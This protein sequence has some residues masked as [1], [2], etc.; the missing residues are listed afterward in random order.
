MRSLAA[1]SGL[2]GPSL[3]SVFQTY[4]RSPAGLTARTSP[5]ASTTAP[6]HVHG[7]YSP[8]VLGTGQ[9]ST[10]IRRYSSTSDAGSGSA[11]GTSATAAA[12]PQMIKRYSTNFAYRQN[13]ERQGTYGSSL[14]SEGSGLVGP[15]A[16]PSSY[17]YARGQGGSLGSSYG[18]SLLTRMEYR[19]GQ[20][21]TG[22][23]NMKPSNSQDET[24]SATASPLTRFRNSIA[25]TYTSAGTLT[26]SPRSQ[27]E[28]I[29]AFMHLLNSKPAFGSSTMGRLG[30][31]R[32]E[33][34]SVFALGSTPEENSKTLLTGISGDRFGRVGTPDS[35]HA[36]P[37]SSQRL[38]GHTKDASTGLR[39]S[40]Y[41][42]IRTAHPLSR[43]Q[44]D[45]MLSRMAESVGLVSLSD[46]ATPGLSKSLS[47]ADASRPLLAQEKVLY[48]RSRA[49]LITPDTGTE[50]GDGDATLGVG[51]TRMA[52]P[53]HLAARAAADQHPSVGLAHTRVLHTI[54]GTEF[55]SINTS[56]SDTTG[57]GAVANNNQLAERTSTTDSNY[58]ME[59]ELMFGA[60]QTTFDLE[61]ELP[62]NMD[63]MT[64]EE[65]SKGI[66]RKRVSDTNRTGLHRHDVTFDRRDA[67]LGEGIEGGRGATL[68]A[69]AH[70]NGGQLHSVQLTEWQRAE[71]RERERAQEVER[72]RADAEMSRNFGQ[73]VGASTRGR[74]SLSPWR[75]SG[76]GTMT[77][78]AGG[79]ASA[80]STPSPTA[81]PSSNPLNSTV[82][83]KSSSN[84]PLMGVGRSGGYS[85]SLTGT[86]NHARR[87]YGISAPSTQFHYQHS[88]PRHSRQSS[89]SYPASRDEMQDP[90]AAAGHDNDD[91]QGDP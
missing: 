36:S 5:N 67:G 16:E 58:D 56:P 19:Q 87:G 76:H 85:A 63:L 65:S 48:N 8:S 15:G 40:V 24:S 25:T 11:L 60:D 6:A 84:R 45:E 31:S 20:S 89:N 54:A 91:E 27:D 77:S 4:A 38:S 35:F 90:V 10:S 17:P 2:T 72:R 33:R 29:G 52:D 32:G 22:S 69:G 13:R 83:F 43:S 55:S 75:A 66:A 23:N 51:R 78:Q 41:N 70:R 74:G 64:E 30:G 37:N 7:S 82:G 42:P 39:S 9:R 46:G 73:E 18:R 44:V 28:E 12:Q 3:R 49:D 61:D 59:G 1:E 81:T 21:N 71:Q 53:R 88:S 47:H 80:L 14:S 34:R 26:P 68:P 50:H 86:D 79:T 62:G 57:L